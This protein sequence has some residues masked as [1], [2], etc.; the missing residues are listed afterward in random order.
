MKY[1]EFIRSKQHTGSEYG[2][3][4][5]FMPDNLFDFQKHMVEWSVKNGRCA[6]LEDCGLG[7]TFQELVWAE[8][9]HR[10]TNKPVLILMPLAVSAQTI[11]EAEKF[12]IEACRS[13]DGKPS[14]GITITN[15]E[16]LHKFDSNDYSG[17]VCDESSILKSFNGQRKSEITDFMRKM[18]YRLLATATAAPND[19]IEL[20]TS[21]EALGHLGYMDMLNRFFK[22]DMNNSS[23]KRMYGEAPKW[24]FKGHAELAF[25]QW[26]TS[27]ARAIRKPSDLGFNDDGFIL[28]PLEIKKHLIDFDFIPD[29]QLFSSPAMTLQTQREETKRS[30]TERCEKVAE[31]VNGTGKPALVWCNRN[32]E[33]DLLENLING[34]VQVAGKHTDEQK[35]ERLLSF[36]DEKT[37]VLITK[38]RIG[39]WGLNFQHC[40]H[41]TY[42]PTHSYEQLYQAIRRCYRFGQKNKVVVDIVLTP[43]ESRILDNLEAKSAKADA[44]FDNLIAEMNN[45][46]KIDNLVKFN[47]QLE[48]PSWL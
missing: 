4:P 13:F 30:I 37:R 28:P 47:T 24:R 26:V 44:M 40:A 23:T 18:P 3:K 17:V 10:H 42:F 1:T 29:D 16:Q 14:T 5:V 34:S 43:G 39:A 32:E 8:N 41:E 6:I 15:Y 25:W 36:A 19:Y 45:A 12:D 11:R 33:G 2:F 38:P 9:V 46:Q 21:S 48:I 27:W 22:N 35:E 7:K 31:L 20:G